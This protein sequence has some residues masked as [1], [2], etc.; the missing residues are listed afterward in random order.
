M[1]TKLD[2]SNP[3]PNPWHWGERAPFQDCQNG[4]C[5]DG[6]RRMDEKRAVPVNS[7]LL[8]GY[9]YYFEWMGME[10]FSLRCTKLFYITVYVYHIRT[11]L[12]PPYFQVSKVGGCKRIC[13]F[14][15]C[16]KKMATH[17]KAKTA[18]K[19]KRVKPQW[20]H[21]QHD[22]LIHTHGSYGLRF[23]FWR[24]EQVLYCFVLTNVKKGRVGAV[25]HSKTISHQVHYRFINTIM[26]LLQGK[27]C[28]NMRAMLLLP[29]Y[30]ATWQGHKACRGVGIVL[31]PMI[32]QTTHFGNRR[33]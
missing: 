11:N 2:Q 7:I 28:E 23:L 32:L 15:L 10:I 33:H 16:A 3:P 30:R 26:A 22:T 13:C 12:D 9:F 19:R 4:H 21:A 6:N 25:H 17:T 20:L 29:A 5:W 8:M 18:S 31:K 24:M 1:T 14:S 27:T